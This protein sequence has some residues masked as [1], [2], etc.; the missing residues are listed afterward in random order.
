MV[1]GMYHCAYGPGPNAFGN[2]FS[3][4]VV[5]PP[6][7]VEDA[8]HDIFIALQDWVEHGV[9]PNELVATKY[10]QDEPALGI[11][12]QRPICAYPKVP[13]YSGQGDTNEAASF[14]CVTDDNTNNPSPAPQYL[15]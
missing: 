3:G 1:P 2:L 10:D 8:Q 15:H 9:A 5:S 7:P 11:T 6:P 4:L 13:R 12:M 14:V